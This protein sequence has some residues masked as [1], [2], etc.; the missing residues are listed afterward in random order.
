MKDK[1]IKE[2]LITLYLH[3]AKFIY[4]F[5]SKLLTELRNLFQHYI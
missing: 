4:D 3:I 5:L 2:K 1:I